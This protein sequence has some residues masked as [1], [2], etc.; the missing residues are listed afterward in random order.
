MEKK[1]CLYAAFYKIGIYLI[2]LLSLADVLVA[3]ILTRNEEAAFD[4][5]KVWWII[6]LTIFVIKAGLHMYS[7]VLI[8]KATRIM[9]RIAIKKGNPE[10]TK[11]IRYITIVG[12]LCFLAFCNEVIGFLTVQIL[13]ATGTITFAD[14]VAARD[15]YSSGTTLIL[16]LAY[17][18]LINIFW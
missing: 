18:I 16:F 12:V 9:Q 17:T 11:D 1:K 5:L 7:I 10:S 14:K 8:W 15:L 4:E 6:F 13:K 3:L 2:V